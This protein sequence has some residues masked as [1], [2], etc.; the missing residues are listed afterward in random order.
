MKKLY[1]LIFFIYF[2]LSLLLSSC[3]YYS[4]NIKPND[5]TSNYSV[6]DFF[7]FKGN[8][9]LIYQS[10]NSNLDDK[11]IYIDY[12]DNNKIQLRIITPSDIKGQVIE[13]SNGELKI[14]NT[15]NEF[16]YI[17]NI[18]SYVNIEPE[19]LLKEPIKL[20]NKW[21][22]P[23]GNERFIS[24]I[25]VDVKTPLGNFTAL[26]V[27]TKSN[28]L[29][30]IDYY[31]LGLGP[32]KTIYKY[33]DTTNEIVI[34]KIENNS[35]YMQI[36]KFYYPN[37]ISNEIIYTK[38]KLYFKTNDLLKNALENYFKYPPFEL[39]KLISDNTKINKV[40][41]NYA[42]HTVYIDFSKDFSDWLKFNTLYSQKIVQ[43]IVNTLAD[44]FNTDK[45]NISIESSPFILNSLQVNSSNIYYVD[46]KNIKEYKK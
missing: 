1:I 40:Y 21:L 37:N 14:I 11:T 2:F 41:F 10:Q 34:D 45:V 39:P 30:T 27:T 16:Y 25:N 23:N 29:T 26:E 32:I 7:T 18:M 35:K 43:C 12:I 9:K 28:N 13:F 38:V 19:I 5:N 46:Y 17:D 36:V 24:G 22:L 33:N 31:A 6:Q 8:Y 4:N 15:R 42:D 3:T 20:G 44:Y